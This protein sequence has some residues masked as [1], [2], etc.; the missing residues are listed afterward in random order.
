MVAYQLTEEVIKTTYEHEK[1][2][3]EV[4]GDASNTKGKNIAI[5]GEPGA[6]SL[7]CWKR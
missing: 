1:F 3:T 5:I 7:P 6:E 4:I 2:L